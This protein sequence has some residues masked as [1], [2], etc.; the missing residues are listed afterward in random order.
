MQRLIARLHDLDYA[1]AK[2]IRMDPDQLVSYTRAMAV[3]D[4]GVRLRLA[5][6]RR[7]EPPTE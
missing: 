7:T 5:S 4:E 2:V 1:R 6:L 3:T